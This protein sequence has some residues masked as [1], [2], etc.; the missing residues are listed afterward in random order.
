MSLQETESFSCNYNGYKIALIIHK[1]Q[2]CIDFE[3]HCKLLQNN[4]TIVYNHILNREYHLSLNTVNKAV[5]GEWEM[6]FIKCFVADEIETKKKLPD[7]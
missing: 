2:F 5:T 6:I 1:S 4:F 7:G 3:N